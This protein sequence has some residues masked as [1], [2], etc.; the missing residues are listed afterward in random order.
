MKA[1]VYLKEAKGNGKQGVSCIC[2][3]V[4][5]KE[6]DIKVA[7]ELRVINKYWDSNAIKYRRNTVV[8]KDEQRNLSEQI[9]AII[10]HIE[11]SF[12]RNKADGNWLRQ[13][14]EDVLHPNL[15]YERN[16][17]NLLVRMSGYIKQHEGTKQTK[18]QI[19][20]VYRKL[21]RYIAYNHEIVGNK[22]FNLFVE[23]ISLEDMNDF[24]DYVTNEHLLYVEYPEFYKDYIPAQYRPKEK[25]STT[26]INTMNLLCV[27]LHWCKKMGY[28]S[29]EVFL[30][31]GCK[32]PA[33]GDPFFLSVKERNI[34]YDADLSDAPQLEV[35]RDIF[36]FHCYIGCRVGDLYRLTRDNIKD[37]FVEYM[38]QKTKGERPQVVRVP[39]NA[40]AKALVEKYAGRDDLKGK[41]FPFISSQKYNVAIKKF[42]T[43][44]GVTRM[45]TVLNPT[46]GAEEKRALNEIASSHLARRTFIGNLYKKVKDPNLVGSLSGHKEGSKAFARYRD[47]DEDMKKELVD[48]LD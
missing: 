21:T 44:C 45:V 17:P 22:D 8:S 48:L 39:L 4:R 31:Y 30:Q 20:N 23:N 10:E 38:P 6:I 19:E 29:N 18:C 7:S 47:I 13:A 14:I 16:H 24:R 3:R 34:L 1:S 11:L 35:V 40:R 26:I 37:G 33:Y 32:V 9:A 5:D 28:T 15:A 43:V 25:S 12:D 46:T 2:F 41:L 27:F 42:F 36:V